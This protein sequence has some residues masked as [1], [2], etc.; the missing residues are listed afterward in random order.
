[1]R[2]VVAPHEIVDEVVTLREVETRLVLLKRC[3]AM[4]AEV[5]ARQFREL[6]P[7]PEVVL[8]VRLVHRSEEPRNPADARLDR[9]KAQAWKALEDP[10]GAEVCHRLD[11]GRQRVRDVV[12]D[13]AA[14]ATGRPR[15]APG[16]DVERDA[17]IGVLDGGPQW[18]EERKVVVRV[19]DVVRAPDRLAR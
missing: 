15:I 1:M 10:R 19:L 8:Q 2:V 6:R 17:E 7:H 18:I 14:V 5:L 11:R 16:G 4:Q 3:E 12:D 13:G 9:R